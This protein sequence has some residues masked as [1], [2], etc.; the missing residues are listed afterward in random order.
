MIGTGHGEWGRRDKVERKRRGKGS[1]GIR[2]QD[3]LQ[4]WRGWDMSPL[5]SD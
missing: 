1:Q 5:P 4:D 3:V 2:V